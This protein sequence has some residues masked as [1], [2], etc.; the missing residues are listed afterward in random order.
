MDATRITLCEKFGGYAAQISNAHSRVLWATTSLHELA[1]GGTA[2]GTGL[3]ADERFAPH[4][5]TLIA[6]RI[7]L[8]VS[9]AFN[10]SEAQASKDSCVQASGALARSPAR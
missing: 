10:H 6:E 3:N 2:V 8:D 9:E 7:G 5:I 1:L 4:A